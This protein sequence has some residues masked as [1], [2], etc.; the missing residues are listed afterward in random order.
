[1]LEVRLV[2]RV[3]IHCAL[4]VT[5]VQG[6]KFGGRIIQISLEHQEALTTFFERMISD[7]NVRIGLNQ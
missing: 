3:V 2:G 5:H 6:L 4:L 7:S 1:M